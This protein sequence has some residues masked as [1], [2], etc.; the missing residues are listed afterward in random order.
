MKKV[1]YTTLAAV[2]LLGMS[3]C[4]SADVIKPLGASVVPAQV[5]IT[6]VVNRSGQAIIYYDLPND[7]NLK[8]VK[9]V[10]TPREGDEMSVNASY[11]TDSLIVNG[12]KEAGEYEVYLYSVS[13]GE[14]YSEPVK[15]KVNPETPPYQ[16]VARTLKCVQSFG[17]VNVSYENPT[18]ADLSVSVEK[19]E[20]D[21]TWSEVNTNY[22]SVDKVTFSAR[23]QD[24][25]PS[26]FRV[27]VSNHWGDVAYSQNYDITPL[28][29]TLCDKSMFK[30]MVL[31]GD[32][33]EIT[34]WGGASNYNSLECAFDGSYKR[35]APIFQTKATGTIPLSWSLDLGQ[36]YVLSRYK[37]YACQ[38][39]KAGHPKTFEIY[40]AKELNPDPSV[41][42][43]DAF[44][45]VDPYFTLL[46][47]F[48]S[49]RP[50]GITVPSSVEASTAEDQLLLSNG[51]EFEFPMGLP[52]VRYVRIRVTS[53]WDK[54]QY[55]EV[56]EI[57]LFGAPAGMTPSE[58]VGDYDVFLL[59]GQSN[60]AGS[61]YMI[62]GDE[63]VFDPNVYLLNSAGVAVPATNPINQYSSIKQETINYGISPGFSFSKKV[64]A[65]TGRKILLVV[66][67][68]GGTTVNQWQPSNT[69][70]G[71]YREAVRRTKQALRYGQLKGIL[72]HQGEDDRNR[73]TTYMSSL[74]T[75]VDALREDLEAPDVPFVAGEI[76]HWFEGTSEFNNVISGIKDIIDNSDYVSSEGCTWRSSSSDPHFSRDGHI[77]LGERYAEKILSMSYGK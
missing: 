49:F 61:G 39:F 44:G 64:S 75:L 67:A 11:F 62:A 5:T 6:D 54:V 38:G 22:S 7:K 18:K 10:F 24:P 73:T 52:A 20:S 41:E 19:L 42:L 30:G 36:E 2:L 27:A 45:N 57:D 51:E 46:G 1:I 9:A 72:W 34:S 3:A 33:W 26:T 12:F 53:T 65:E 50:S 14:N 31:G 28:Y 37:F 56:P 15:V 8:Y 68:R 76:A 69:S 40:G 70:T 17:G 48:E 63:N 35:S 77:I 21:G 59:I 29:E 74:K 47:K 71:Y 66:N 58:P 16:L 23:G 13:F 43:V 4:K 55:I 60:M 25:V 32:I